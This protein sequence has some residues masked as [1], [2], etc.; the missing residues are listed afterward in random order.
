MEFG[1]KS[2]IGMEGGNSVNGRRERQY[3]YEER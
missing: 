3:P 1:M 2:G